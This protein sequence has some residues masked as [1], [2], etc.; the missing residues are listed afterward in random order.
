MYGFDGI[1]RYS[2][3]QMDPRSS[4]P[5]RNHDYYEDLFEEVEAPFAFVDLDAMWANADAMLERARRQ[6]GPGRL[7]VDPL[8]GR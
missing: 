7:Q 3:R 6:A 5:A 8:P 2:L 1:A 4:T